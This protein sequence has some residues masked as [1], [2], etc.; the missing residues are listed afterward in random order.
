MYIHHLQR[1]DTLEAPRQAWKSQDHE[2]IRTACLYL[3]NS[4]GFI[5]RFL[6]V[7]QVYFTRM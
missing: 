5:K 1:A 7:L 4:N 3:S 6:V 2:K